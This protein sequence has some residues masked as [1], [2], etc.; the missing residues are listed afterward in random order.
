MIGIISGSLKR[1]LKNT[2]YKGT[3][4]ND[5]LAKEYT[6]MQITNKCIYKFI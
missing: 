3:M 6:I 2:D 5:Y 1:F 4:R